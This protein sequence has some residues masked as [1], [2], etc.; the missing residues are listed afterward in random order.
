MILPLIGIYVPISK[1]IRISWL[2]FT[3]SNK[4]YTLAAINITINYTRH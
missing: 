3:S 4:N 2:V 1:L